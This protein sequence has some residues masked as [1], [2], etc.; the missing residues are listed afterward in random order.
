MA[1]ITAGAVVVGLLVVILASGVLNPKPA[2]VGNL[3]Q[4]IQ[5]TPVSLIDAG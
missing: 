5:P 4:P 2:V 3:L 1:L